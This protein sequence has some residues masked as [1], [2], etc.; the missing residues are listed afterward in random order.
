VAVQT[1]ITI[2]S[3]STVGRG[4]I[5]SIGSIRSGNS[6]DRGSISSGNSGNR[7]SI[8]SGNGSSI[9]KTIVV[10]IVGISI[11]LW[12]SLGLSLANVVTSQTSITISTISVVSRGG[13]GSIASITSVAREGITSVARDNTTVSKAIVGIS[14]SLGFSLSI[15][16]SYQTGKEN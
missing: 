15:D 5:G 4:G 3:I 9:S 14:I 6:G 2:T 11:S 7:G 13:I 8:S 1:S 16:S 12:F 10:S